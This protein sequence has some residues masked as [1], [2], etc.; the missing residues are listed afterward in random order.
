MNIKQLIKVLGPGLMWAGAAVGVSHLVQSTRAG[1]NFGFEL[2]WVLILA[3]IIKYPFFEFGPRYAA[4]TG[5]HLVDGYKEIGRWAVAL[6]AI[7][8][9][10]TMFII[11]GA[12]T[13]VTAGLLANILGLH[14]SMLAISAILLIVTM[15][16]IAIGRYSVLDKVMKI[17]ILTL[18]LS[19]IIAVISAFNVGFHP[20]PE[21]ASILIGL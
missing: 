9:V 12:I 6:Y 11:Q 20:N 10:A 19:T 16:I 7:L 18:T 2:L 14:I 1:A 13:I 3:N 8:T 17:I 5:K 4:S 21:F 15:V